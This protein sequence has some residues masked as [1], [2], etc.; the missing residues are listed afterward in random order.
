MREANNARAAGV[1]A[2][3]QKCERPGASRA[4]LNEPNNSGHQD[5]ADAGGGHQG[6]GNDVSQLAALASKAAAIRCSLYPL[7]NG[8]FLLTR[9]AWGLSR[10][11]PDLRSVAVLLGRMAGEAR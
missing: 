9:Q 4:P 8:G 3:G 7:S 1:L 11:L 10:E 6:F 5:S 2:D